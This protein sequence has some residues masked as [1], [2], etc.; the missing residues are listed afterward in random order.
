[1]WLAQSTRQ[2]ELIYKE[3]VI[4]SKSQIISPLPGIFYR[5]SSPSEPKFKNNGDSV[6]VGD[7]IGLIEVMK[8][9]HQVQATVAGTDIIFTTE[10]ESPV[11]PGQVLAE[12]E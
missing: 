3:A 8:S 2:L 1:M 11:V 10:N 4:M 7:V 5:S 12:V 6:S 9:F